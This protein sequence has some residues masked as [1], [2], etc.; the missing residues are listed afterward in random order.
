MFQDQR[1]SF[2][3]WLPDHANAISR[4]QNQS[5]VCHYRKT[6]WNNK[7]FIL[8][9]KSICKQTSVRRTRVLFVTRKAPS[10]R[11]V[12]NP[13]KQME[14]KTGR[15]VY[16][17]TYNLVPRQIYYEPERVK[18]TRFQRRQQTCDTTRVSRVISKREQTNTR[19][20]TRNRT[21][22]HAGRCCRAVT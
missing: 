9:Q 20:K 13:H 5:L 14:L 1:R 6:R 10:S 8:I 21:P 3:F 4:L 16:A 12:I 11:T 2:M 17:R 19:V 18:C 15:S 7:H 22:R